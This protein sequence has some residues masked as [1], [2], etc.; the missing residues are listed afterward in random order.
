MCLGLG[1]VLLIT[2]PDWAESH[3]DIGA[4]AEQTVLVTGGAGFIGSH[5][6]DRLAAVAK[7]RILDNF[8]TGDS[9]RVP[10]DATVLKGD[11]RD[12]ETLAN[13][14]TGVDVVFHQAGMVSVPA[15]VARPQECHSTNGTATLAVLE[16]A[17]QADARVVFASS[18]AI[19]GQPEVVPIAEDAPK[20]PNS[21]YGIEKFVGDQ[22]VRL[23]AERYGLPAVAL[24]YFNVYGPG[25]GSQYAGVISTFMQQAQSGGPITVEG[26]G[27]QTRDFVHVD[28][29]VRANILA[30][31]TAKTGDAFNVGT[32]ERTTINDLARTIR[33]VT[34][35]DARITHTDPRSD[36]IR[37]SQ[38]DIQRARTALGFDPRTSLR[39]GLAT[40]LGT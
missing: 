7:V 27:E 16:A 10:A 8:S 12:E 34:D 3:M 6:A 37:H 1:G 28:D 26:D 14:M 15:S 24:R 11:I 13:A 30:A 17:R 32:G 9:T 22:Y 18:A 31:T 23:Y 29:V 38:A 2:F 21:P 36:D 4:L 19:Y 40:L 5:L 35:S 25:Q 20:R 33:D 39:E